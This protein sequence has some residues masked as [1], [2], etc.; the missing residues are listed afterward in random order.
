MGRTI[1]IIGSLII[2]V[3]AII[4]FFPNA[5]KWFGNLPGDFKNTDGNIKFYFPLMSMIL[6]SIGLNILFKI[7]KLLS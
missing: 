3:G 7:F 5:F 6:I 4:H 1:I 2:V